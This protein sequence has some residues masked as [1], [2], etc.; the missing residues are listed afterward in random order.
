MQNTL[1]D[2]DAKMSSPDLP[3]MERQRLHDAVVEHLQ[4]SL[5]HI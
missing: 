3:R 5:I 4:L 2:G 1:M